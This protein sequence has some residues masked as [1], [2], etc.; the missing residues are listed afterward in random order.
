MNCKI[1]GS[2]TTLIQIKHKNFKYHVCD[3]CEFISSLSKLSEIEE[4]NIYEFHNNTIEDLQYVKYFKNFIDENGRFLDFGSGPEPV[5]SQIFQRDYNLEF[6]IYDKFYFCNTDYKSYYYDAITS[7][8]VIEH[9]E[10]PLETFKELSSILKSKGIISIMTLL[11]SNDFEHFNKWW[12]NHDPTHISFFTLKTFQ[13]IASKNDLEI[14]YTDNKR[15]IT[16][17]KI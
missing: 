8:E 11:H 16:F 15:I 10:Y 6:T 7:T 4:K 14:I 2:K 9:I 3:D 17:Q 5:L 1:C 12:Y 13:Y